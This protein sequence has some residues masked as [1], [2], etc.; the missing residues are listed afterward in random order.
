MLEETGILWAPQPSTLAPDW[1]P[2]SLLLW[3]LLL[4]ESFSLFPKHVPTTDQAGGGTRAGGNVVVGS[5][6]RG[7]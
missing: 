7:E 4:K 3:L 5:G 6:G 1:L 2:L